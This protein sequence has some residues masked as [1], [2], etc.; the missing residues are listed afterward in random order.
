MQ[1]YFKKTF[2]DFRIN[3]VSHTKQN[4]Y[5]S[6]DTLTCIKLMCD[7]IMVYP[8]KLLSTKI[9]VSSFSPNLQLEDYLK[10]K[11][12]YQY[13]CGKIVVQDIRENTTLLSDSLKIFANRNF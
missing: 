13:Y 8:K 2:F 3:E 7:L 11:I 5:I 12:Y 10:K 9:L 4:I 6:V 1:S